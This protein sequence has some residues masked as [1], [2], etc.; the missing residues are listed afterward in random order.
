[1][2]RTAPPPS[3]C[4]SRL[5]PRSP[6]TWPTPLRRAPDGRRRSAAPVSGGSITAPWC[7]TWSALVQDQDVRVLRE[8]PGRQDALG[9]ATGQGR[10]AT[11]PPAQASLYGVRLVAT[12]SRTVNS[13]SLTGSW[14]RTATCG[15][16]Q[17]G[18]LT[19]GHRQVRARHDRTS[20]DTA[21]PGRRAARS[22]R[23]RPTPACPS[24]YSRPWRPPACRHRVPPPAPAPCDTIPLPTLTLTGTVLRSPLRRVRPPRRAGPSGSPGLVPRGS[25]PCRPG[26]RS[27]RPPPRTAGP[28]SG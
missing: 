11:S 8:R 17:A 18:G 20:G 7:S 24:P 14:N 22:P 1:M 2:G 23:R 25:G 9:L 13:K 4:P 27:P 19:L 26:S 16:D 21:G 12:A 6:P 3:S 28:T 10:E 5:A 15:A